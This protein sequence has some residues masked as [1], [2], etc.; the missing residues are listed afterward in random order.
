MTSI[1][2]KALKLS[3]K[4][5]GKIEIKPKIRIKSLDDFAVIYTP[6]VAAV[7]RAIASNKATARELTHKWNSIAIITDGTRVLGLGNIG[8]D[9]AMPV[10]EGKA[11]LFKYLGGVDAIPITLG[12]TDY[13]KMV[14]T[15]KAIAPSFGGINLEDIESPKSFMLLER[16]RN[17]LEIPIWHDDNQ[18]TA[19]AALAG[20]IN[21]LKIVGKSIGSIKMVLVGAGTA[22]LSILRLLSLY[23]LDKRKAVVIDSKGVLHK[24]RP[25]YELLRT[26]NTQKYDAINTTNAEQVTTIEEAFSGSDVVISASTPGPGVIKQEWLKSMAKD[27]IVFALANPE[28][29]ISFEEAKS[30][31]VRVFGTGRS[32]IPNQINNS[33][34]FPG[35]FRGV[36][37]VQA[38]H[39]TDSMAVAAAE[40]LAKY[41]QE[42]GISES[43]IIPRM[44]E[45]EAYY[46]VAA[47]VGVQAYKDG[48]TKISKSYDE[49]YAEA[50]AYIEKHRK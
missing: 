39:I 21:A 16:L 12:V 15:I 33:L 24:G 30:A 40:E 23:G 42:K 45:N 37:D 3:R 50:K 46:R 11:L 17:E 19:A 8:P 18:G 44:D 26:S 13:E 10:M 1:D 20:L 25:D 28:P 36:L 49:L 31:G 43:Y 14:E 29:E 32:D 4:Y 41:A 7:S 27:P 5:K 35:V 2:N 48:V 6:G 34:V 38:R 9:A 22:N 47:G